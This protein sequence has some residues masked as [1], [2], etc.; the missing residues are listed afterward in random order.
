MNHRIIARVATLL[1]VAASAG[2]TT[3]TP[4]Y[5]DETTPC[6]GGQRCNLQQRLCERSDAAVDVSDASDGPPLDGPK[7]KVG[8]ACQSGAQCESSFCADGVCCESACNQTCHTC[9][10]AGKAGT[11]E[12]TADGSDP[13]SECG[14]DPSCGGTCNGFGACRY[15]DT[16][17][18]CGSAS[19]AAGMR[20]LKR[21]DGQGTCATNSESCGGYACEANG[22]CKSTCGGAGDCTG[23]AQCV[24]TNCVDQQP[25]GA[26]C[27]TNPLACASGKCTDG[28]CCSVSDCGECKRCASGSGQCENRPDG[29]APS[30]QCQGHPACN[31]GMCAG[32][33][34]AYTANVLCDE[35]CSGETYT[36][37]KCTA[38]GTCAA[39]T[40]TTCAP[41]ACEAAGKKCRTYCVEHAD[42]AAASACDRT[43]AET[44]GRGYCPQVSAIKALTTG[45]D[46]GNEV[47]AALTGGTITHLL[48]AGGTYTTSFAVNNA[49]TVT[50]ISTAPTGASIK[51]PGGQ[52]NTISIDDPGAHIR[53]QNIVV[54]DAGDASSVV[55]APSANGDGIHCTAGE[56][57]VV[58]SRIENNETWGIRSD[59]C[60]VT[61]RRSLISSNAYGGIQHRV[62][63]KLN[64]S[65]T[66]IKNNSRCETSTGCLTIGYGINVLFNASFSVVPIIENSTIINNGNGAASSGSGG[67]ITCASA[68]TVRNCVVH[69][70]DY[71]N[72]VVAPLSNFA[73]SCNV[74]Y[75]AYSTGTVSG[76]GNINTD[77][78]L[79]SSGK[80]A[81]AS[82]C[83]NNGITSTLFWDID[84]SARSQGTWPDFGAYEVQ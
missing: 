50:L 48:L 8:E 59:N 62:N 46:L 11:C 5:C 76:T 58:E 36:Q 12:M 83:I 84:R 68:T 61:V 69:N 65:N 33:A 21:C 24:G 44:T 45:A 22:D 19:C 2:C 72:V 13:R 38:T 77:C 53:L 17:A 28:V 6:P 78:N 73:G 43:S 75:T 10:A 70:N 55:G 30:G 7:K 9:N 42:C 26:A 29:P 40:P 15:P 80:P 60:S 20:T 31:P 25:L 81:A 54:A 52:Q 74:S 18:S 71:S 34:C 67:G 1:I 57:V 27:G 79:D 51:A 32:G 64:V 16:S 39:Q 4:D 82:M 63:A 35:Q 41:Y 47:A 66:V 3:D 56:I 23:T 37:S 14:S 49:G